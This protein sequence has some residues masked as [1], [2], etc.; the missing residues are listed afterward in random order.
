MSDLF[1]ASTFIILVFGVGLIGLSK[2]TIWQQDAPVFG[3]TYQRAVEDDF[4]ERL[5]FASGVRQGWN[6]LQLAVFGQA[7]SEV[8]VAGDWLFTQEEFRA[9]AEPNDFAAELSAARAAL[10][11]HDIEL[12]PILVPDKARMLAEHLPRARDADL[13]T[14]YDSLLSIM[15]E[16]GFPAADLRPALAAQPQTYLRTDTHWSPTGARIAAE[17][18]RDFVRAGDQVFETT[19]APGSAFDAD[20]LGLIDTGVLQAQLGPKTE[21]LA[22][23]QTTNTGADLFGDSAITMVLVGTSFSA[24]PEFNFAGALA[25]ATGHEVLNLAEQGQGP[26]APMRAAL[27]SGAIVEQAPLYVV[28]EIPERYVT[29]PGAHSPS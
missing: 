14:R 16:E 12:I 11:A 19:E 22:L 25:Q 24:R 28:W 7:H 17:A 8:Y 26:F 5:P 21:T 3:G 6:A 9:P 23:A 20:L 4:Q 27:E 18:L 15:Q 10:A 1:R 2:L 29:P 13:E